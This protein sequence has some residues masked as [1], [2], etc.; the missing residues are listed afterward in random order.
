MKSPV[1]TNLRQMTAECSSPQVMETTGSLRM[2][3][4]DATL[5]ANLLRPIVN[6][7]P[8][9]EKSYKKVRINS[10]PKSSLVQNK[11]LFLIQ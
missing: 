9:S 11:W 5:S 2:K 10:L 8:V 1:L 7:A 6:T 4:W 3:K